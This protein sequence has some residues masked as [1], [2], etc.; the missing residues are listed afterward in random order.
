MASQGRSQT[1]LRAVSRRSEAGSIPANHKSRPD[2]N[3]TSTVH[4]VWG[5]PPFITRR[6]VSTLSIPEEG[7]IA[8]RSSH[9]T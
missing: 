7:M 4:C 5:C 1:A 2:A 9:S 8:A 3:T 6:L